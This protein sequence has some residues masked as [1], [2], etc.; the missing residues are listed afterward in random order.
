MLVDLFKNKLFHND[1]I[2]QKKKKDYEGRERGFNKAIN[3][4]YKIIYVH[5]KMYQTIC[6]QLISKFSKLN[7]R[8]QKK[9]VNKDY[10]IMK[11]IFSM[12]Y[13]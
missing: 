3:V 10:H 11:L 7:I 4:I 9:I 2:S 1:K 6:S 12:L 13:I 5:A 8:L